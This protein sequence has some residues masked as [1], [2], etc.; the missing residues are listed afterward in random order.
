MPP[1]RQPFRINTDCVLNIRFLFLH[2][3]PNGM[4]GI[5]LCLIITVLH[6]SQT[7]ALL[8]MLAGSAYLFYDRV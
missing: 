4:F 3:V 8:G 7:I 5:L 2:C 6:H 1:V